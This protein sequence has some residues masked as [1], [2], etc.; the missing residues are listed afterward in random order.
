MEVKSKQAG[1][2]AAVASLM[3]AIGRNETLRKWL[4]W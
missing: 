3:N 4:L 1:K 2:I